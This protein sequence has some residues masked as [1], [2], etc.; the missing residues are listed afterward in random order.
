MPSLLSD[1]N[2]QFFALVI[3]TIAIYTLR[4]SL[5][6]QLRKRA[7][8]YYLFLFPGV[9]LHE[10]SHLVGCLL[11]GARV[12]SFQLFSKD[13]G[14]V[15]HEEP[16]IPVIG[17]FVVSIFPLLTGSTIL[18]FASETLRKGTFQ[19]T[20]YS[21]NFSKIIIA[22]L[23]AAVFITMFPS[24]QDFK[25]ASWV[26]FILIVLLTA[27]SQLGYLKFI[28]EPTFSQTL[29]FCLAILLLIN[30]TI[31]ALNAIFSK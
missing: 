2:N 18:Y 29:V 14:F 15:S 7:F 5:L 27:F 12:K 4:E 25:N 16:R 11:T 31:A 23:L 28:L 8:W 9:V 22:Y 26:Y 6:W 24:Y 13:G 17:T 19:L 3:L 1:L 10:V 20:L 30:L 21:V